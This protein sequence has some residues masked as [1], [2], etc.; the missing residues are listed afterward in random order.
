MMFSRSLLSFH[1]EREREREREKERERET[2]KSVEKRLIDENI[3][4]YK[5]R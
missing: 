5:I 1:R 4:Q 2:C 3:D